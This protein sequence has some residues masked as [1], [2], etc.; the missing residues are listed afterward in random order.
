MSSP[1]PSLE[2]RLDAAFASGDLEA[3]GAFVAEHLF[4]LIEMDWRKA[5]DALERLPEDF[6]AAHPL[7]RMVKDF[8]GSVRL[9]DGAINLEVRP[10]LSGEQAVASG[11]PDRVLDGI[12]LQEML[13]YRFRSDFAA[14]REIG[15]RLRARISRGDERG[16]RPVHDLAAFAALQVGI[17]EALSDDFEQ[18]LRDFSEARILRGGLQS[19]LAARDSHLKAALVHA[20]LGRL[21]EAERLL[22]RADDFAEPGG[23]FVGFLDATS[24]AVWALLAVDRLAPSAPELVREA[25]EQNAEDEFWSLALLASTR[26]S[27]ATGDLAGAL[28]AVDQAAALRP[29][30]AGSLAAAI[31]VAARAQAL[32]MLGEFSEAARVLDSGGE[33]GFPDIAVVRV[34]LA[35]YTDGPEAAL[36]AARRLAVQP[37]LGPSARAETMLLA[38]WAQQSILGAPEAATTGPLG[39]LIAREGIWRMLQ[40]VPDE[41]VATLP[42]L[43]AAPPR[44]RGLIVPALG[45]STRLSPNE[46]E[47]LRLLA[48]PD[49]LPVIAKAR[50]VTL[51]TVKTQVSSV[52]RRLGA[53]DRRGAVAEATRRG[54]LGPLEH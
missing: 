12:L 54:I 13:A 8:G 1:E 20:V 30:P 47:I 4:A 15:T 36:A 48:G 37:G 53:H 18:A 7:L 25:V 28:E 26:W 27:I 5:I 31:A 29:M 23:S 35:L 40:L 46:L 51:N 34:R 9:A 32:V 33:S 11:L 43:D 6:V 22:L 19:D 39:S 49:S 24:S 3:A 17:T 14:A 38:A 42:G 52:Y 10:A 21:D 2:R 44:V 50:F 16:R 41:V 45:R